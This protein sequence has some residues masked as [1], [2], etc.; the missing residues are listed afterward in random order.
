MTARF[1]LDESSWAAA[2][3]AIPGVL[4]NA[5]E[6]LLE[7]LDVARVRGEVVVKPA[8]YYETDLGDGV[9]LFSAL[10]EQDCPVQLDRDLA[11][12]LSLVLDQVNAFDDSGLVEYD[13]E[14]EGR[15]RFALG[16]VWAHASC[17]QRRHIAVLPLPLDE[18]P[19]GQVPV[20]VAGVTLEIVFVAKESQHVGFFRS[21]ISLENA[22][23]AMFERLARSA[24]PAL[25]WA[26]SIWRSLGKFSRP[27]IEVRDELVRS[28][29][30]LSDHGA[31]CFHEHRAGDPHHLQSVLSILVGAETSDENGRTKTHRPSK[32]DR[33][34]RHRGIEKVFWWHVKLQPHVD[35]IYFRYEPLSASLPSPEY[36]RVVVGLFKNHCVLPTPP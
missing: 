14:F 35:R 33:T 20:T 34:R 2:T 22:D 28:L 23:E 19:L 10:F 31:G 27:Y 17:L 29:G 32:R 6:R 30:G 18:V 24:F 25:E 8:H 3:G 4:S 16:V 1:V 15:V 12:R 11:Y 21:V 36:G 7:R 13:A 26:D 9:Q 5:I